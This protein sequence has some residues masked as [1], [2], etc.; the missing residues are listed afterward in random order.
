MRITKYIHN[1]TA[2]HISELYASPITLIKNLSSNFSIRI[3]FS[4]DINIR[5]VI[6]HK[7]NHIR[8][9]F[10]LQWSLEFISCYITC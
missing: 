2:G 7:C 4:V 8:H 5:I 10:S 3:L 6:I 1:M 9:L